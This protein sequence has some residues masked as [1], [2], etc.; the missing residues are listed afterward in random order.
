MGVL[1]RILSFDYNSAVALKETVPETEFYS[2]RLL[3]DADHVNPVYDS[4]ITNIL[5]NGRC[6]DPETRCLYLFYID[7]FFHS[8]WIIEINID[9]RNQIVV[10]FDRN[11]DIGFD[12]D[13]KIYN[14]RVV[15]GKLIW[16]DNLNVIYQMDIE[17][18]KKSFLYGIGYD[19]YPETSEWNSVR[20]WV[21]GEIVSRGNGFYKCAVPNANNDP[22]LSDAYWDYLCPI[23]SAYYSM[24]IENFY[25][26][27]K[28]PSLAPI[29]V[30][31]QDAAR[32]INNLK[33]TLFQ[34]A[35]NYIYMD[36]RESTYSPACIVPLPQSEEEF[37][38]GKSN[39]DITVNNQ[40]KITVDTGGEEVRKI[41]IIGR[42]NQ[43]PSKWWLVDEIDKLAEGE[44]LGLGSVVS[45]SDL[46]TTEINTLTISVPT[47]IQVG[48]SITLSENETLTLGAINPTAENFYIEASVDYL[49]WYYDEYI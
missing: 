2:I 40:L 18:A 6:I 48:I 27:P 37:A 25:F 38:T 22:S 3:K 33:Q 13:H 11:N 46:G 31:Q 5:L 32:K 21:V 7:T 4:A 35:Y 14:P 26:A 15:Y 1:G 19:P 16:T 45:S 28:P 24:R 36:Y 43:D 29:V 44:S 42:S 20:F 30:Y 47:P 41:R 34:F 39:E 12:P 23:K 10:Y 9:T 17:R 49:Y 8:A